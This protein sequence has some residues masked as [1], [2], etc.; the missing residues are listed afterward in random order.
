[1]L[2]ISDFRNAG[3]TFM[4]GLMEYLHILFCF[5]K[6]V[7]CNLWQFTRLISIIGSFTCMSAY[8]GQLK[9]CDNF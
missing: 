7:F 9:F 6:V 4:F 3:K 8:K 5:I 2:G 1:M